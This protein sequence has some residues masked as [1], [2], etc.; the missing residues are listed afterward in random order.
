MREYNAS[1]HCYSAAAGVSGAIFWA[2]TRPAPDP[3]Q[4]PDLPRDRL[5][6]DPAQ[7]PPLSEPLAMNATARPSTPPFGRIAKLPSGHE[8]HYLEQGKGPAV[9]LVHGSG[10]GA[11]GYSNFKRNIGPIA[12]AGYRVLVPDMIGFGWS[13]KPDIDYPLDLFVTTLLEF[14]DQVGVKRCTLVGNSLG[15][16]ISIKALLDRPSLVEKLVMMGTGGIESRETYF[17]MPGIRAMVSQ[18]VGAGFDRPRLRELLEML[19]FDPRVVD[20]ALLEERW[21]VLQTQP[22]AVLAR[23]LIPDLSPRLIDIRCPVLGFWGVEDHFCPVSGANKILAAVGDS[24]MVL[25]AHCGHWAMLEYPD[26]FNR[27]VVDFLRN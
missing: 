3:L 12:E 27:Y 7:L 9:V 22:K 14:L 16:A 17:A 26:V 25:L 18:F 19:A 20:D 13:S 15:G 24:R 1:N 5:R 21:S 2:T 11:N 10:P 4:T 8:M 23:M 6:G